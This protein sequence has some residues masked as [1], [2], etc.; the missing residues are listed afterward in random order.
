MSTPT[1]F[2]TLV[3]LKGNIPDTTD[4]DSVNHDD[5]ILRLAN[6]ILRS[7]I[8]PAIMSIREDYFTKSDSTPIIA[9]Q[10]VYTIPSTAI[11]GVLRDIRMV[12]GTQELSL[13][14]IPPERRTQTIG[15][16]VL[17]YYLEG[18]DIVL[19]PSPIRN[20]DTLVVSYFERLADIK[21]G[22]SPTYPSIPS[23]FVDP[24]IGFTTAAVLTAMG[25]D[26]TIVRAEA[27]SDLAG[28]LAVISPRTQGELPKI[29]SDNWD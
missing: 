25:Q 4:T 24:W 2:L 12:Q 29:L 11:A 19:Y 13:P 17:G 23:E 5:N 16:E 22:M 15:G 9:G 8:V 7:R 20:G 14:Y 3:K 10:D 26:A 27:A 1:E 18:D 28:L 6:G 21:D